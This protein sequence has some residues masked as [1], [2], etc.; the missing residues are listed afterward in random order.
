MEQ[1]MSDF[2]KG[3]SDL[4]GVIDRILGIDKIEQQADRIVH[5]EMKCESCGAPG[6]HLRTGYDVCPTDRGDERRYK[7]E[8]Y[9]DECDPQVSP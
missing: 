6:T 7:E 4:A 1:Q 2:A 8:W 9:C 5:E 3:I